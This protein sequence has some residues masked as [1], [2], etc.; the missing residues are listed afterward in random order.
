MPLLQKNGHAETGIPALVILSAGYSR[1]VFIFL[2]R[3]LE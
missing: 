3:G 1:A 2:G